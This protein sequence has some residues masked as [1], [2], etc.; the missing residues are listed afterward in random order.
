M[1]SIQDTM[2]PFL[3]NKRNSIHKLEE[4]REENSVWKNYNV[5]VK[6]TL[7]RQEE[8]HTNLCSTAAE[9]QVTWYTCM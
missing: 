7:R 8:K 4:M 3:T 9:M 1:K 2:H 5:D 6:S